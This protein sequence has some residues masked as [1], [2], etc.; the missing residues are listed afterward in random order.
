MSSSSHRG[1]S[2]ALDH[3]VR[4]R[5]Q[6]VL[7]VGVG[8][9]KWGFLMREALDLIEGRVARED[10]RTVI[11]GID[12]HRYDSPLLDWVYDSVR[13]GDAREVAASLAGYDLVVMGDVIEHMEKS[14]GLALLGTLLERNRNVIVTTPRTFFEQDCADNPFQRHLSGWRI[15]DFERWPFDYDVAGGF[16]LVVALA[17]AGARYPTALDARASRLAYGMPG[18]RG[19]GASARVVKGAARRALA[20]RDLAVRRA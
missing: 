15:A 11:D 6:R 8:L 9:G 4:M 18:L 7:D 17:G 19:R 20:A 14:D 5:P 10:W 16:L 3:V 2:L 1:L 12:A 13:I